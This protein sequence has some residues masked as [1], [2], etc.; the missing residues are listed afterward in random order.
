MSVADQDLNVL[1]ITTDQ[2]RWDWLGCHG[3]PGVETPHLD[4]LAAGGL[5]FT[6]HV[7]NSTVCAPARI[8]LATGLLPTRLEVLSNGDTLP[9]DV[10]TYYQ[11]LRDHGYRVGCVGKLDLNKPEQFNGRR[12][13]RPDLY[14]W[15]FTHPVEIE[16]KM[17]AGGMFGKRPFG[18]YGFWLQEQ[19]L[20]DGFAADY[21]ARME[22]IIN[23]KYGHVAEAN[24]AWYR[25]SVLSTDAFADT[26]IGQ[27]AIQ[28][29]TDVPDEYPWHLFVSFVGPH[30]PFD[31]PAE[32]ADRFRSADLPEPVSSDVADK[33]ERVGT[34]QYPHSPEQIMT[35][36]RQYTASLALIDHQVGEILAALDASGQRDDTLVI[37]TADH[38]EM[39][40]DHGLFQKSV[41]YEPAMRIPLIV[42][43]PGVAPGVTDALTELVDVTA[44]IVDYAG[45]ASSESDGRSL[46]PILEDPTATIREWVTCG[47]WPYRAI[48]NDRWKYVH[49]MTGPST[50]RSVHELY[51]LDSDPTETHNVI[52]AHVDIAADLLKQLA[53]TIG[54]ASMQALAEVN[55]SEM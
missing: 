55:G 33:P 40:G 3:T 54:P 29:L 30:D 12:G 16:G 41:P 15:G 43:G 28:W 52:D 24:D 17:H 20:W 45:A 51:D 5:R 7:T 50:D 27:R 21:D 11:A 47:E 42:N 26:Y 10:A 8:G 34:Q 14:K 38:G 31:P 9:D 4:R 32:W 22:E 44:T 36:R 25:D 53:E 35:A 39:L 18:P 49:N 23:A 19:G 1:L 2:H 6:H 37:F 46:R 13:D 48:R